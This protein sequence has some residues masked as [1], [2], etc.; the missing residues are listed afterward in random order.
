[1]ASSLVPL[2]FFHFRHFELS[3]YAVF[4]LQVKPHNRLFGCPASFVHVHC[5]AHCK[6]FRHNHHISLS[7]ARAPSRLLSSNLPFFPSATVN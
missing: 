6:G 5:A 2:P 7:N 1:M 3:A 4:P